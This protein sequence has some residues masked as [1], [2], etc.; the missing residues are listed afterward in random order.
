MGSTLRFLVA[1][2]PG[3]R[4]C[5]VALF[6]LDTGELL[7]AG[8]PTNPER[9]ARG[10][11]AWACMAGAVAEF[12][13]SFLEP[14][15]ASGAAVSVTVASECPQVYT[16]GKS[17]G[18]PNDLIELAGVVG[19]VAGALGAT[20]ERS[21]LPREWKGTL[22]ADVMV[23][24]IKARLG[25]RPHEHLR[26]Q[27]PRAQDKHHNVWDAVGIGLHFVGRLAPR[28]VFPR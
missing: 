20:S 8:M 16:A 13:S 5:G 19:R 14:L 17:K 15:R 1:L 18:D 10:L 26:V 12:L 28:K 23:E 2:D 4:E 25:E 24:R 3:L 6:N 9:Q 11:A 27:L 21:Y 22:D 7:A